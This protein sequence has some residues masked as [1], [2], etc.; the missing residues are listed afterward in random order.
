MMPGYKMCSDGLHY[1]CV[2]VRIAMNA[3]QSNRQLINS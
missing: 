2:D 1:E 3:A